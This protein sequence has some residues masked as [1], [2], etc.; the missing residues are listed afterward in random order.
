MYC[1][2]CFNDTLKVASSGVVK[3]TFNGKAKS[4]SQFYY[5]IKQEK[6]VEIY[7]KFRG[8]VEDYFSWYTTFQNKD[9][10]KE[11]ELTSSDFVCSKGCKLNI[12]HRLNV[13]DL[14][15]PKDILREIAEGT[16]ERYQIPIKLKL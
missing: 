14:I 7:K 13:I 12:S 4:T 6:P 2:V 16:A 8:V 9:L 5:N 1:P 3:V 10:I 11:I 15:I